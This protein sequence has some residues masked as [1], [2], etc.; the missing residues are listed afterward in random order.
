M[1]LETR[2]K[3]SKLAKMSGALAKKK[4]HVSVALHFS[5]DFSA[6]AVSA[7]DREEHPAGTG[8][9]EED[10]R[11]SVIVSRPSN[12]GIAH[13]VVRRLSQTIECAWLSLER[14]SSKTDGV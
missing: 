8:D 1:E 3:N 9:G 10:R 12:G 4:E 6:D 13:L 7:P 11:R 2:K 5:F 14:R